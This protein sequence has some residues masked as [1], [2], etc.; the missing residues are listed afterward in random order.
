MLSAIKDIGELVKE[1]TSG[2]DERMNGQVLFINLDTV[3]S[4][5][6]GIDIEDFDSERYKGEAKDANRTIGKS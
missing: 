2:V 5:Y 3:T 4:K 6:A 1:K